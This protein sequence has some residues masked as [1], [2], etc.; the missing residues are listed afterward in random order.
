MF[1]HS[2]DEENKDVVTKS[3]SRPDGFCRVVIAT[4][5]LGMGMDFPDIRYI[6]NYGPANTIEQLSQQFGRAGRD[7]MQFMA[8]LLWNRKQLKTAD[9]TMKSYLLNDST[10]RRIAFLKEFGWQPISDMSP[11]HKCCDICARACKCREDHRILLEKIIQFDF[12]ESP[13]PKGTSPII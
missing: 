1:H 8:Y 10:C 4:V 2:T 6:L 13:Q 7:Q 5:A 9:E 12:K 11:Q 3:L